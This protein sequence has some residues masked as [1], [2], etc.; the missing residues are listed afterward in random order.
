MSNISSFNQFFALAGAT[1]QVFEIGRKIQPL[2]VSIFDHIEQGLRPYPAPV[3][4][5]GQIAIS[6]THNEQQFVWFLKL[7]LDEN[8]LVIAGP[9]VDFLR[10]VG[11]HLGQDLSKNLTPEQQQALSSHAINFQ[12]PQ[13]KQAMFNAKLRLEQGLAP[14]SQ[15][16]FVVEYF[17]GEH[18]SDSWQQMG[19]QGLADFALRAN[20]HK[21][22]II[23]QLTT[24][25]AEVMINL[26]HLLENVD[27]DDEIGQALF[28]LLTQ[29]DNSAQKQ[30][31][32]RGLAGNLLYSQQ[33][34]DHCLAQTEALDLNILLIIAARHHM[35]LMHPTS[36][37]L[38]LEHMAKHDK[39]VFN[40]LF[41][42]LVSLAG[43]RNGLLSKINDDNN[44]DAVK[45]AFTNMI[46]DLT[47]S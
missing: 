27:I 6:Y 4:G 40:Q 7:P 21:A 35:A 44:S 29:A 28:T 31:W 16:P 42:D 1:Y 41:A 5:H 12:P 36:L 19:L 20:E 15:Y 26:L 38:Y 47:S 33:A 34:V 43:L 45:A 2:P 30:H 13:D 32:L 8:G 23:N 10:H 22:L 17:K 46:K 18:P 14:S 25:D 3:Q 39:D 37:N 24:L 11:G 9:K